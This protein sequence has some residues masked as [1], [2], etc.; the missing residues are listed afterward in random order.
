MKLTLLAVVTMAGSAAAEMTAME[1]CQE[2]CGT[3]HWPKEGA[4]FTEEGQALWMKCNDDC[5]KFDTPA[6]ALA[7]ATSKARAEISELLR[8]E[9]SHISHEA[10]ELLAV[11]L[12]LKNT[13]AKLD[14][15]ELLAV[16]LALKRTQA[17][18]DGARA[19]LASSKTCTPSA[20]GS[21]AG[22]CDLK[23]CAEWT[24]NGPG[25]ENWCTCF[26]EEAE[27]LKVFEL[28][29]CGVSDDST[30]CRCEM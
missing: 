15:S 2:V 20:K 21:L 16:Q 10:I 18:L 13:Q 7:H 19:E 4:R 8:K 1:E 24:C 6:E 28:L 30:T 26:T 17:E 12:V 23:N 14:G 11:Q 3:K 27:K 25:D 9:G 29:G 5:H 22:T